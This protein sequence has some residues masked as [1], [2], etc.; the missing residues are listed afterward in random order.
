MKNEYIRKKVAAKDRKACIVC[1]NPTVTVLLNPSASDWFYTCEIHLANNPQFA[2]PVYPKEY[3]ALLDS[4]GPLKERIDTLQRKQRNTWDQWINKFLD[5]K[6]HQAKATD[7]AS[8]AANAAADPQ[9]NAEPAATPPT[10]DSLKKE[11]Q[12]ALDKLAVMR[13]SAS[14]FSLNDLVLQ[15]RAQRLN[16]LSRLQQQ[17]RL[18]HESYTNTDPSDLLLNMHFPDVPTD[19]PA[20]KLQKP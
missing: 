13:E 2:Q 11:Y 15:T 1:G 6:P 5:S 20:S 10:L 18:E 19:S 17:K 3:H 7:S 12:D 8:A 4:L 9:P 16:K 14:T